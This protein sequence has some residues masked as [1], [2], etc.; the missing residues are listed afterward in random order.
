MTKASFGRLRHTLVAANEGVGERLEKCVDRNSLVTRDLL[1]CVEKLKVRRRSSRIHPLLIRRRLQAASPWSLARQSSPQDLGVSV[2]F[3]PGGPRSSTQQGPAPVEDGPGPIDRV[4]ADD[5]AETIFGLDLKSRFVGRDENPFEPTLAFSKARH[6]DCDLCPETRTKSSQRRSRRSRFRT[7]DFEL[8]AARGCDVIVRIEQS[9]H[10][11]RNLSDLIEVEAAVALDDDLEN[12][13]AV[14]VVDEIDA[15]GLTD[16]ETGCRMRSSTARSVRHS[17]L[18]SRVVSLLTALLTC[19][20]KIKNVGQ[21][22]T[23]PVEPSDN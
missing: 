18:L 17:T 4:V 15:V 14:L 22:T 9:R 21:F 2:L 11:P 8:I 13:A 7:R 1:Q 19:A 6:S 23:F 12:A 10:G 3:R 16:R 5:V 20:L